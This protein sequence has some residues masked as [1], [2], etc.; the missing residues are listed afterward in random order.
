MRSARFFT[1][2]S[3]T[4][5]FV[6]PGSLTSIRYPRLCKAK[7]YLLILYL[8]GSADLLWRIGRASNG[9]S[10]NACRGLSR[11]IQR[12]G[13][14][15]PIELIFIRIL[16]RKRKP[17]VKDFWIDFP[18]LSMKSWVRFLWANYPSFLLGG[19][20][21]HDDWEAM[22]VRFWN[23]WRSI[24]PWHDVFQ[25]GKP[26]GQCVPYFTHGDEGRTLRKTPFMVQ[27]WQPAISW[28]GEG[29]TTMS[30]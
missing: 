2:D 24:Q 10:K 7:E 16:C 6:P 28:K 12:E 21:I 8:S 17:K 13:L 15:V 19:L 30:G 29:F 20:N 26:L 25:S 5:V 3:V 27:S 11:L 18:T 9:T 4:F 14:A 22:H 23:N 1:L